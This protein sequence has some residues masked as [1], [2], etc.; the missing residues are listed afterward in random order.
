MTEIRSK[1]VQKS[2]A[3]GTTRVSFDFGC[4]V[5]PSQNES[6]H[7]PTRQ[8]KICAVVKQPPSTAP[9]RPN[10]NDVTVAF[11]FAG[12]VRPSS[13]RGGQI[14]CAG[15]LRADLFVPR[16]VVGT[17]NSLPKPLIA[18]GIPALSN[19]SVFF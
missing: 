19:E 2:A 9:V 7:V 12:V 3:R 16:Y 5:S 13:Q 11:E 8:D 18:P 6:S 17:D 15:F 1:Q 10:P 14:Y 4:V